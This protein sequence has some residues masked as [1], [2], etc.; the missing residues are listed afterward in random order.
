VYAPPIYIER[1]AR[2][3]AVPVGRIAA[4]PFGVRASRVP[5]WLLL[6][7]DQR[8]S[9]RQLATALE[10]SE[11]MVSRSVRSLADDRLIAIE[12][13]PSDARLRLARVRDAGRLLDALERASAPRKPRRVTWDIGARDVADAIDAVRTAAN[14]VK[15]RYAVGGV[16]GASLLRPTIEPTDVLVWIKSEDADAWAEALGAAPSVPAIGRLTMQLTRDPFL[17]SLATSR[18]GIQV[19]DAVQLYLDC[20]AVGEH[21]LEVADAIQAAVR[22]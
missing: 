13:D 14:R 12:R 18:D 3:R 5:R 1:P 11:A 21:A 10:L 16:A 15:L 6:H 20:R 2:R 4:A 8:P 7:L 22:R 9:F 19:A 17:L